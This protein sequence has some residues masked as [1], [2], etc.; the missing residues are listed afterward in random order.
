MKDTYSAADFLEKG[1]EMLAIGQPDVAIQ[2]FQRGLSQDPSN[3]SLLEALGATY[4]DTGDIPAAILALKKSVEVAPEE[5]GTAWMYLGQLQDAQLA[6]QS[7]NKGLALLR[8]D[9]QRAQEA[10]TGSTGP[11]S[12]L[13]KDQL[14]AG[15]CA[16]A[17]LYMTDLCLHEDAEKR[18]EEMLQQARELRPENVQVLQALSSFRISQ[19]KPE[20][21]RPLVLRA[22]NVISEAFEKR[23][24]F[25][26]LGDVE[27][28][29]PYEFRACT[30]KILLELS[31]NARAVS[32]LQDLVQEDDEI[33]ETWVL[34]VQAHVELKEVSDC[35]W[36][37]KNCVLVKLFDW[38]GS[39]DSLSRRASVWNEQRICYRAWRR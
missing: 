25:T 5:S 34:L 7:F 29:P 4:I 38:N 32:L 20:E 26:Q 9:Y 8:R 35:D 27:E 15:Y 18:C 39:V 16:V 13:L 33:I 23:N 12:N 2:F 14:C 31:E 3:A 37:S 24:S 22:A 10:E 21:A 6:V 19:C 30:A 36:V 11:D 17:E 1:Q 28:L